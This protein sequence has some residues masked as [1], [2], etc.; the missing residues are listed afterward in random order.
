MPYELLKSRGKREGYYVVNKDT[1]KKHSK[2]PLSLTKAK[3]QMRALYAAESGYTMRGGFQQGAPPPPPNPNQ[4]MINSLMAKYNQLGDGLE[5]MPQMNLEQLQAY[6]RR[7]G[8]IIQEHRESTKAQIPPSFSP[9]AK[10]NM[11]RQIE[12]FAEH[13]EEMTMAKKPALSIMVMALLDAIEGLIDVLQSPPAPMM[14]GQGKLR[15]GDIA[16]NVDETLDLEGV[17]TDKKLERAKD[18][19]RQLRGLTHYFQYRDPVKAFGYRVLADETKEYFDEVEDTLSPEQKAANKEVHD[20]WQNRYARSVIIGTAQGLRADPF[21]EPTEDDPLKL[22]PDTNYDTPTLEDKQRILYRI[23]IGVVKD[24]SIPDDVKFKR[25]KDG[26]FIVKADGNRVVDYAKIH[27]WLGYESGDGL[28]YAPYGD[29]ARAEYN[30]QRFGAGKKV[31]SYGHLP[32]Y[33]YEY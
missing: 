3:A 23:S 28:R 6:A 4:V 5:S 17:P 22:R 21:S 29:T 12:R 30:G 19:E 15:G 1:R 31:D 7:V 20:D 13:P 25:G 26:K 32:D 16:W 18:M 14:E 33:Y 9:E 11:I 2:K 27:R 24:K 8:Q 10:E